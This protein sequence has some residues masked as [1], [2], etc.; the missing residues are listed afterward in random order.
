MPQHRV[1]SGCI[2][3]HHQRIQ[4]QL[5]VKVFPWVAQKQAAHGNRAECRETQNVLGRKQQNHK[6]NVHP[7]P[8]S[9]RLPKVIRLSSF[10]VLASRITN[11]WV[12]VFLSLA[13]KKT[14][15]SSGVRARGA[16]TNR[17]RPGQ[18]PDCFQ[19]GGASPGCTLTTLQGVVQRSRPT[20]MVPKKKEHS[21]GHDN[22]LSPLCVCVKSRGAMIF[23]QKN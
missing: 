6:S 15:P 10:Q 22:V 12:P 21:R 4:P 14:A 19:R 23:R 13:T 5:Q 17:G 16:I 11:T 3:P 9:F 8:G 20:F 1:P 2:P 7:P 18:I